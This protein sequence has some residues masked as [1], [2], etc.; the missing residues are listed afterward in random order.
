MNN[1]KQHKIQLLPGNQ[2]F[3]VEEGTL[4]SDVLHNY[5]VDFPCGGKGTCGN[6]LVEL[7]EGEIAVDNRHQELLQRKHRLSGPWRLACF[8][9]VES[10]LLLRIPY[11]DEVILSDDTRIQTQAE[12]GKAIAIDLGSTTVVAQLIDRQSGE[13]LAS[14]AEG[15]N[16]S[17]CGADVIARIAYSIERK[18]QAEELTTLIRRQIGNMITRLLSGCPVED[19]RQVTL[20]G[21][22]VMHH[23]F[24]GLDVN[25]FATYPFQSETQGEQVFSPKQ[26]G[27]DLPEDCQVLF[28]PN[29]SHFVGS[30]LLAGI[31]HLQIHKQEKW[32]A[33][34]DLGTNGEIVI[35]N[36][37]QIYCTS[38]AAGPA[39]EG[40]NITQGMRAISGAIYRVELESGRVGVI[41]DVPAV[42]ICGSGLIDAIHYFLQQEKIDISGAICEEG[43][44]ELLLADQVAVY[45]RDIREFQLAKAAIATGFQLLLKQAGI[46]LSDLEHIYIAGG[47]GT[48]LDI[49]KAMEIGLL[50]AHSAEQIRQ[51]GN[52]ALK[53]CKALTYR[54]A[55][56]EIPDILALIR[57]HALESDISFQDVYCDNLC[58]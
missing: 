40:V 47:L 33:L 18:E 45:D 8:S 42:G 6:C 32:Q 48:Y 50:K 14:V 58:F 2:M 46:R 23:I 27:W 57:H 13:V 19:I 44:K 49:K 29:L 11:R 12:E 15:N 37:N 38:T 22:S 24:S 51:S 31:Y 30:D 53:G 20:V 34:L 21:N 17:R 7:L 54:Q 55:L 39:F 41:G 4:L 3:Q 10:D 43:Q 26:L 56:Q 16:Q 5:G 25:P 36:C 28:L 1:K 35:G 52:T 9:R